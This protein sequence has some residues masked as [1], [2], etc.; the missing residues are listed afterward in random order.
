MANLRGN[1]NPVAV[2]ELEGMGFEP[3]TLTSSDP[4]ATFAQNIASATAYSLVLTW[5]LGDDQDLAFIRG[6]LQKY[7]FVDSGAADLSRDVRIA[8]YKTPKNERFPRYLLSDTDYSPF[9]GKTI[10]QMDNITLNPGLLFNFKQGAE[11]VVNGVRKG[12]NIV[13]R[14]WVVHVFIYGTATQLVVANSRI[15]IDVMKRVAI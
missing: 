11:V 15:E 13:R 5:T 8:V 4:E 1:P 6:A 12:Y 3:S 2:A 14:G 10:D 9:Y 7:K